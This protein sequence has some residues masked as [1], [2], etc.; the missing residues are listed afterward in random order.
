MRYREGHHQAVRARIL[1][2]ATEAEMLL[3]NGRAALPGMAT[4]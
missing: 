3:V 4:R 1:A 2:P